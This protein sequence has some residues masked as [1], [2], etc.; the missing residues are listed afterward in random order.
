MALDY[1]TFNE[2]IEQARAE[3]QT[4]LPSVDPTVGGSWAKA[5]VDGSAVMAQILTYLVRD[6]EQQ[7]FPQTAAG[8]FLDLWGEYEG[9][10]RLGATGASGYIV[11]EAGVGTLIPAL[12][13][14]TGSNGYVYSTQTAMSS[15]LV[16][17]GITTITRS[18]A[19][20]TATCTTDHNLATGVT[21]TVSGAVQSEY[22]TTTPVVVTSATTFQYTV[23]GTP[24]TPA[25]GTL[26]YAATFASIPVEAS[27]TGE[28]TNIDS[29]GQL[30]NDDYGTGIV[31]YDNLSGGSSEET[32][33]NYRE[34]I[35]LSRSIISGVFTP[36]QIKLAAMSIAGNSRVFVK[37]PILGATGGYES[38]YPGQVSVFIMRTDGEVTQTII[39]NTKA[40][41]VEDGAMPSEMSEADLFVQAPD[42]VETDFVF[43][44]LSPDTP[45]MRTAIENQLAA[46]FNDTVEFEDTVT[47]TEYL[48]AIQSS[49][50]T[51]TGEYIQSFTLSSPVGDIT[52]TD[53]EIATLGEVTYSV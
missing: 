36:D 2:L 8:D 52:V 49:Q 22:N 42:M 24:A 10:E 47:Q 16:T 33:N 17:Q 48:C 3:L 5:F 29:G 39:N 15:S 20:A 38:P 1:P 35:L 45:T 37:K 13:D 34:R 46:F 50:S 18:G 26:K 21:V 14:F 41:I 44:A 9:L 12:T 28:V 31:G 27:E 53:G 6:L 43:S 32:D 4:Q 40:A 11:L 25:T 51:E 23:V 19:T 30:S 7:L